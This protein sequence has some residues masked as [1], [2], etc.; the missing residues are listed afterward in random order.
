ML[1]SVMNV[2]ERVIIGTESNVTLVIKPNFGWIV[3]LN[4][5]PLADI[6]LFASNQ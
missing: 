3:I 2:V 4:M 1:K 5:D 6:E